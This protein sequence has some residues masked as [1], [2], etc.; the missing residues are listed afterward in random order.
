MKGSEKAWMGGGEGGRKGGA[1]VSQVP[2]PH[3]GRP[4]DKGQL[5]WTNCSHVTMVVGAA[6][7]QSPRVSF[8]PA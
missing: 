7:K 5:L 6:F 2:D 4:S 1:G 8:G 3:S